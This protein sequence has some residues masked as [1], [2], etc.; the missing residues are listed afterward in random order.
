M[1]ILS[2]KVGQRICIASDVVVFVKRIKGDRV[3]IGIQAPA[4]KQV[5]RGELLVG[6]PPAER[7]AP[8]ACKA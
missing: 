6:A 5:L 4:N 8:S 3:S 7:V 1:L 2:R